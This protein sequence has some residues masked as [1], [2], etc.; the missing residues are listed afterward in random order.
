MVSFNRTVNCF[1]RTLDLVRKLAES[2]RQI[3]ND[4]DRVTYA[5]KQGGAMDQFVRNHFK[6]GRGGNHRNK[7]R[8]VF[9]GLQGFLSALTLFHTPAA[10]K[11]MLLQSKIAAVVL[12]HK[13]AQNIVVQTQMRLLE[14][15][16]QDAEV[17]KRQ[18]EEELRFVEQC[19][20][21]KVART[22]LQGAY[23]FRAV[24]NIFKARQNRRLLVWRGRVPFIRRETAE[25]AGQ[26]LQSLLP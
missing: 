20:L 2:K 17:E 18:A 11:Y 5:F 6:A 8:I 19:R 24:C 14:G 26:V 21:H 16:K 1:S 7:T 9:T 15:Q 3:A 13:A 10:F 23:D 12:Q 25:T 4:Y 22:V